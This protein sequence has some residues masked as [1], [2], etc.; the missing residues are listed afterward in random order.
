LAAFPKAS[1]MLMVGGTKGLE[2]TTAGTDPE[3]FVS[4]SPEAQTIHAA[5]THWRSTHD[6]ARDGS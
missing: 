4:R 2:Q 6:L 3:R 1:I 5:E